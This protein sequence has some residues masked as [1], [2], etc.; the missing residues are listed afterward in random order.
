MSAPYCLLRTGISSADVPG[1]AAGVAAPAGQRTQR[2]PARTLPTRA[3]AAPAG[4]ATI[5]LWVI[6]G[7][8]HQGLRWGMTGRSFALLSRAGN[9]LDALDLALGTSECQGGER[10]LDERQLTVLRAIV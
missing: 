3:I 1:R 5:L 7:R 2:I 9:L 10:V 8:H 6:P 4:R